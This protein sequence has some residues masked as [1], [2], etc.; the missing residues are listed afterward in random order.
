MCNFFAVYQYV[1]SSICDV[2]TSTLILINCHEAWGCIFKSSK[3]A[4][5]DRECSQFA[6]LKRSSHSFWVKL[7]CSFF[8][9]HYCCKKMDKQNLFW[10]Y[11]LEFGM[12]QVCTGK[13]SFQEIV[14]V[15]H[16][17]KSSH[18]VPSH[19]MLLWLCLGCQI[20]SCISSLWILFLTASEFGETVA[21]PKRRAWTVTCHGNFTIY[22]SSHPVCS[23]LRSISIPLSW[24]TTVCNYQCIAKHILRFRC[25]IKHNVN[26]Y[27]TMDKQEG[28]SDTPKYQNK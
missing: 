12:Y 7:L 23:A 17:D 9:S 26:T 15:V 14:T 16:T 6:V 27:H 3:D 28:T 22:R 2:P 11:F 20:P 25:F 1:S 8:S 24:I 18:L 4:D 10:W 19:N 21:T 5:I 13:C